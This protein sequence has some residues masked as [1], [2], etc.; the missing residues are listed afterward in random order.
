MAGCKKFN[1]R[2]CVNALNVTFV[3]FK[4]CVDNNGTLH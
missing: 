4:V 3:R 1:Q 2:T